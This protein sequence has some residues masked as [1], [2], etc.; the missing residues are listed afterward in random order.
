MFREK[1]IIIIEDI[2]EVLDTIMDSN[3]KEK[4]QAANLFQIKTHVSIKKLS[5][6]SS[7]SYYFSSNASKFHLISNFSHT[8]P[9]S[10]CTLANCLKRKEFLTF[11][12]L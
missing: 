12:K 8:E 7:E 11:I 9:I 6:P 10:S 5:R 1:I 3:K 2:V 4:H